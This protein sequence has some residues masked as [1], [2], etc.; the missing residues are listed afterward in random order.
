[1]NLKHLIAVARGQEKADLLIRGARLVN[2]LTS[3]IYPADVA[4]LGDRIIGIGPGY[5]A[6]EVI[7][8]NGALIMPG[9]I[10][11]H[12]HIES[13]MCVPSQFARV[14]VPHGTT[15]AIVDAHEIANVAGEEGL[16][17][18]LEDSQDL[19]LE[20]FMTAPSC[21]PASPYETAGA[22][23][24]RKELERFL[25]QPR[26][27]GLGEMM[28]FP[29]VLN[30]DEG[31]LAKLELGGTVLDGHAPD[32]TGQ[33][34]CAYLAAGVR[35]DHECRS[36]EEAQEK[37]R[38][39]MHIMVRE[40]SLARNL[41]DLL[42]VL[43]PAN[44]E[45]CM[46][47]TDDRHADD[48]LHHGSVNFAVKE[49]ISHG[50]DPLIA[51]K[52]ATI[53]CA[54]YFGRDRLG[55]IAPGWQADILIVDDFDSFTIETVIKKG[56]IVA[57]NGLAL[58]AP[59]MAASARVTDTVRLAPITEEAFH[60]PAPAGESTASVKVIGVVPLQC[61]SHAL[62]AN[63][64]IKDGAVQPDRTQDIAKIAVIERHRGTGQIGLGFVKGFGIQAGAIASTVAH[65]AHNLMVMGT[66]DADMRLAA[67]ALSECQGGLCV[68]R[69]GQVLECL[70]LPI[71][72][73]MSA[74][75]MEAVAERIETLQQVAAEQLGITAQHPFMT[76]AFLALSVIPELKITDQGYVDVHRFEKVSVLI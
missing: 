14:V 7:E 41:V 59:P 24:E 64:R 5:E 63:L 76:L 55:A 48:L 18:M 58:F 4:I 52:M 39:G 31:V 45:R 21:V 42:P 74:E 44:Q 16:A 57:R 54:R 69:D 8:A 51:I 40:G 71:A 6:R 33:D 34:L 70:P 10:D 35:S 67:Q 17:F 61:W 29:G 3:E 2:V 15:T 28:N 22:Q 19:P 66:N 53:N 23:L 60:I 62:A 65:D 30:A 50:L 27:L 11:G 68:V 49:A 36:V 43:T 1:M 72:G 37:L 75:P 12:V 73:L 25:A 38:L 9:F 20:V 13:S 26:V 47:A 56:Q 46:F 32:L